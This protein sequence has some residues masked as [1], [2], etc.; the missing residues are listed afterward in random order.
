MLFSQRIGKKQAEKLVQ[1]ECIDDDLRNSLWSALTLFYWDKFENS[2]YDSWG[3][4][5]GSNLEGLVLRLWLHFFKKPIDT[6]HKFFSQTLEHLRAYFYRA[7]WF[8]VYDFIEFVAINGP[9]NWEQKFIKIVNGYLERE[10]S[11]YRFVNGQLAEI[12]SEMEVQAVEQAIEESAL[13]YGTKKHLQT[14]LALLS[15]RENPDYR[16]SIKESISVVEALAISLTGNEKSTLGQALKTF[17]KSFKIHPALRS[18]F[19]S[20]YGYTSDEGGIRHALLEEDN[21]T[22]T[23]AKFMLVSCSA[24]ISYVIEMKAMKEGA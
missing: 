14:A 12:T 17:E 18:A 21:L 24:F 4:V 19:S 20:L 22:K 5:K 3:K 10:N 16:N 7:E 2:G 11:A 8:E 23:D 6:V 9:E 13:Y 1:R 15:N